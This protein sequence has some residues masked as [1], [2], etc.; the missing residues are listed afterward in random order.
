M[1]KYIVPKDTYIILRKE[2]YKGPV[3]PGFYTEK[4]AI[5]DEEDIHE[6]DYLG[7]VFKLP[8]NDLNYEGF[9]VLRAYVIIREDS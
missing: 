5:F 3:G 8:K 6:I 4:V 2:I 1:K 7:I 9:F